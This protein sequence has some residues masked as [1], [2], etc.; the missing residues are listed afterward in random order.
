M[1]ICATSERHPMLIETPA[2]WGQDAIDPASD[3][4]WEAT[5]Q[6]SL[7]AIAAQ[8]KR[9]TGCV[10]SLIC[11]VADGAVVIIA[12]SHDGPLR[13]I[14]PCLVILDQRINAPSILAVHRLQSAYRRV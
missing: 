5:R 14:L 12:E 9:A 13:N 6:T 1:E 3:A 7:E 4:L 8:A 11:A 2:S 10:A